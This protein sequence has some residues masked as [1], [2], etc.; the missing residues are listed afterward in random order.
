MMES[1]FTEAGQSKLAPENGDRLQLCLTPYLST[2]FRL[3]P[4]QTATKQLWAGVLAEP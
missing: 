3:H 4:M 2:W 1:Y